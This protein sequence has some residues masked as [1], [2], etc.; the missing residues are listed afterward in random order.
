MHSIFV[1]AIMK[2][3]V[4]S[5][6]VLVYFAFTCGVMVTCHYCMD[7]FDSFRLY[8]PANDWCS[9]CGMHTNGKG[10]CQD[11]VKIVK[12]QDVHQTA[13]VAL[14]IQKLQPVITALSE[15]LSAELIN[16]NASLNSTDHS[17]PLVLSRQDV[18]IQNRVFRI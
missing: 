17:P 4:A 5:F 10:C 8:Q 14:S 11:Q 2:K 12:I 1:F 7:R 16:T 15:F 6:T 3:I 13:S 9:T 18:Y